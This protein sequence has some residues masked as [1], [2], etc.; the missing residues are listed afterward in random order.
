MAIIG[1]Q[2]PLPR[3]ATF[4]AH[5]T[6]CKMTNHEYI[7]NIRQLEEFHFIV[8]LVAVADKPPE[9]GSGAS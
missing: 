4:V 5:R 7:V 1:I 3:R 2:L 8:A 9:P 6:T